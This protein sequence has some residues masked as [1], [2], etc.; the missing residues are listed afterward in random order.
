MC[1]Y[2]SNTSQVTLRIIQYYYK[3][4]I[5]KMRTFLV[6]RTA[7]VRYPSKRKEIDVEHSDEEVV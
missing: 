7:V 6:H 3:H 5:L 2:Q 1:S 4:R